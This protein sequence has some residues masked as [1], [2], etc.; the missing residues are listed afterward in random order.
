MDRQR[1]ALM[2][3]KQMKGPQ[4]TLQQMAQTGVDP[5]NEL[6]EELHNEA[7]ADNP[8]IEKNSE[9]LHADAL[10]KAM[11]P[12]TFTGDTLYKMKMDLK[13]KGIDPEQLMHENSEEM[14]ETSGTMVSSGAG[15]GPVAPMGG[16][17]TKITNSYHLLKTKK[18]K[19]KE[20]KWM[21]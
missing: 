7:V 5:N 18:K 17:G 13:A 8:K 15:A 3:N 6:G 19:K 1:L 14:S 11:R 21:L 4:E 9:S 16:L 20:H 2:L 12:K 10:T